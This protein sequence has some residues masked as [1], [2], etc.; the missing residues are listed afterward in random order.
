MFKIDLDAEF[1]ADVILEAMG[2]AEH[3][4]VQAAI[5]QAVVDFSKPYWAWDTGYLANSATGIGTG[6]ITYTADYASEMYYG[7]RDNG[8]PI[9]YH[10]D[11]NPLAGSYPIERMWAAHEIDIYREAQKV[12]DAQQYE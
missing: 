6:R 9:N 7:I 3:G 1:D 4:P 11:I 12:V 5:D 2:M 8:A 10:H